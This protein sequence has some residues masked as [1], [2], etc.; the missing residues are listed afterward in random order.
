MAPALADAPEVFRFLT[1]EAA[2]IRGYDGV[3]VSRGAPPFVPAGGSYWEFGCDRDYAGKA[4]DS[5]R[6]RTSSTP[7][8]ERA[9]STLVVFFNTQLPRNRKPQWQAH[10]PRGEPPRAAG[11][12][13]RAFDMAD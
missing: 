9:K 10:R 8:G 7:P 12:S 11:P 4:R 6:V 5:V 2:Q 1:D 3:L 13:T